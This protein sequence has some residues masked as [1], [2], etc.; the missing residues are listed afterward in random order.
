MKR[1][2]IYAKPMGS[3]DIVIRGILA[4]ARTGQRWDLMLQTTERSPQVAIAQIEAFEPDGIIGTFGSQEMH[5][6]VESLG[7]PAVNYSNGLVGNRLTQVINDDAAIGELAAGFILRHKPRAKTITFLRADGQRYSQLRE[8]GFLARMHS[9]NRDVRCL[10]LPVCNSFAGQAIRDQIWALTRKL[11]RP[12]AIL[13]VNDWVGLAVS[14]AVRK[15]GLS[16]DDFFVLGVDNAPTLCE[17]S[18]PRLSSVEPAWMKIGFTA[19]SV[20]SDLMSGREVEPTTMIPPL[21]VADRTQMSLIEQN[22]ELVSS[23][24]SFIE[25][26]AHR[27]IS[28]DEITSRLPTSRKTLER[29]VR[30]ATGQ[31]IL[32]HI[33]SARI[34]RAKRLLRE[35]DIS[36]DRIAELCG[37]SN[38]TNFGQV[39]KRLTHKTPTGYR[40]SEVHASSRSPAPEKSRSRRH[41]P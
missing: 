6:H 25:Q 9:Q 29:R 31:T 27:P 21:G 14:E 24:L 22:D 12:V 7:I 5:D 37:F 8:Q 34:E 1:I 17:T 15:A 16:A 2:A 28:V 33:H 11:P 41:R 10:D 26:S 40:K 38:S 18:L 35:T 36:I 4:F 13:A 3:S 20:L 32:Q 39:F 19:A 30:L 23:A